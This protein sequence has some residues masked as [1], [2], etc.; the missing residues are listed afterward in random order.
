M[1]FIEP[2]HGEASCRSTITMLEKVHL[3]LPKAGKSQTVGKSQHIFLC[4]LQGL[5]P[6]LQYVK[7]LSGTIG[8]SLIVDYNYFPFSS[9]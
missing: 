3:S 2:L 4:A 8:G 7:A 5:Y 9:T 6:L 1:E